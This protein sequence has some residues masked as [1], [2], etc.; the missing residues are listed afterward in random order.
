MPD[1]CC[2]VQLDALGH[3]SIHIFK[4]HF[5][6]RLTDGIFQI[7]IVN[8]LFSVE[9]RL[10]KYSLQQT[11]TMINSSKP[12]ELLPI[13][14][15]RAMTTFSSLKAQLHY[16]AWRYSCYGQAHLRLSCSFF[17]GIKLNGITPEVFVFNFPLTFSLWLTWLSGTSQKQCHGTI[18][19]HLA[20]TS[21]HSHLV[22][23]AVQ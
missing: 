8:R 3:K 20:K 5:Q 12:P 13:A 14:L 22:W 23:H 18:S 11:R 17:A 2:L 16:H 9:K 10:I 1:H 21:A 7:T 4:S 6:A 15:Q 19:N